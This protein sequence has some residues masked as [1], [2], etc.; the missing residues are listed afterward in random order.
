MNDNKEDIK[1][2]DEKQNTRKNYYKAPNLNIS[3]KHKVGIIAALFAVIVLVLVIYMPILNPVYRQSIWMFLILITL[4]YVAIAREKTK[5]QYIIF[6][7]VLTVVVLFVSSTP[8]LWSGKYYEMLGSVSEESYAE[9]PPKIDDSKIPVVDQS[10]AETLGDKMLGEGLGLGSQYTVGEYYFITTADDLAWVAP[11]EPLSFFKWYQNREGAPG[12]VYV[13]ATNPSDVRLV[14]QVNGQDIKLKYTNQSYWFKNIKRHVYLN[15]NMTTGLTD[16]SFEI[17]DAGNPYWVVTTYAPAFNVFAGRQATGVVTVDAQTGETIRYGIDDDMPA[18]VERVWPTKFIMEQI[19]YYGYYKNGWLNSVITQK[20]MVRPTDGFSYVFIEG[21]PYMYTGLTSVQSDQ[22][23]VGM[24][25]VSLRD[26]TSYFYKLTGAT[27]RAA[28]ASSEG[29]VQQFQYQA[30]FPILLNVYG[31]PTYFMTLKDAEGLVKQYAFVSVENYDVVGIG[32]TVNSARQDFYGTLKDTGK[33]VKED[34][35]DIKEQTKVVDRIN[36]IDG[37]AYIKFVG[38][39]NFYMC[40]T[41]ISREL[42]LTQKG[43][44]ITFKVSN[45]SGDTIRILEFENKQL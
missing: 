41:D 20:E 23:T 34:T 21:K 25:I 6:T 38:D 10:L 42:L 3:F 37:L 13:S 14:T 22:S 26:K 1:F 16:F 30:T 36:I 40:E 5:F 24:M 12:Y 19:E 32:D 15:G 7:Y 11:L 33:L 29:Q 9:N 17:D 8:I 43:D 4:C 44:E 35:T 39:E 27:E 28:M 2:D 18:W 45:E 31:E